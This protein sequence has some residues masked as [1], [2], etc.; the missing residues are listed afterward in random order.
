MNLTDETKKL[1]NCFCRY[2]H[3]Q[4]HLR[5]LY[6]RF[7]FR[8]R[9]V[10][11]LFHCSSVQGTHAALILLNSRNFLSLGTRLMRPAFLS[12][13]NV[14]F[15][16]LIILL[17]IFWGSFCVLFELHN[18]R[19]VSIKKWLL[20]TSLSPSGRSFIPLTNESNS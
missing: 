1:N 14:P 6:M 4:Q 12:N 11:L 19:Y 13:I 3:L 8:N 16:T 10:R 2:L 9:Y 17:G 5:S 18:Q 7:R 15:K 20:I